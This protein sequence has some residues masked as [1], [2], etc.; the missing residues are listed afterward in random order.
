MNVIKRPDL[1]NSTYRSVTVMMRVVPIFPGSPLPSMATTRLSTAP[2]CMR[3]SRSGTRRST[4]V[5]RP[6]APWQESC[7]LTERPTA[8]ACVP[9]LREKVEKNLTVSFAV[10]KRLLILY[11]VGDSRGRK[12]SQISWSE[13]PHDSFLHEILGVPCPPLRLV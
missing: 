9:P 1:H 6:A 3:R 8:L 10:I 12:L 5:T 2:S 4:R 11:I 7:S 13:C